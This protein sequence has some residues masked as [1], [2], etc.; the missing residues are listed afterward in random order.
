MKPFY[1][2]LI[3]ITLFIISTSIDAQSLTLSSYMEQ[4]RVS[5]K[6]GTSVGYQFVSEY[7]YTDFIFAAEVGGFYQQEVSTVS[8]ENAKKRHREKSFFGIYMETPLVYLNKFSMGL[9]VRT[10]IQNKENFMITPS[11][12]AKYQP[13]DFISFSAGM[14]ARCMQP[15]MLLDVKISL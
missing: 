4:T 1:K 12:K 5:P 9:N 13:A 8:G 11:I 14:G 3:A 15:T 6:I 7:A 10:G 2:I